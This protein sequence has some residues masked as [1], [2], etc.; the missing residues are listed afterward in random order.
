MAGGEGGS[1]VEE[2][3]FGVVSRAHYLAVPVFEFQFAV[4]P[5]F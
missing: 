2:E 5:P 4:D 1:F 3:E